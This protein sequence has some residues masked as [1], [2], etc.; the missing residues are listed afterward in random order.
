MKDIFDQVESNINLLA[1]Q[2]VWWSG[3]ASQEQMAAAKEGCLSLP[4]GIHKPVPAQWLQHLRGSHVLCLAGAG[5]LQAPLLAAAGAE[6]TVVDLSERMLEKDRLMAEKYGLSI[7]LKHGNM[8]DLE[9]F[10]A[11]SFDY[12]INPVSLCYV[13]DVRRVFKQC[14]R[15]LKPNGFLILAAP[16]PVNYLCDFVEDEHGGFYRAAHRM[17]YFSGDHA[18][19]GDWIEFGHT[20]EDY[21]GGQIECGFVI[22][23]YV[24]D[25]GEDITELFFMTKAVRR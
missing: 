1:S 22:D 6:V 11:E 8:I 5:G 3:C 7:W 16:N 24:E 17:P 10:Q 13:P 2:N 23:G 9:C 19:Q 4:L 12:I 14:Y 15:I 18:G 25:Q 20:M 21:I